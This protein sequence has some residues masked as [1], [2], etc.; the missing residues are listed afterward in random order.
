LVAEYFTNGTPGFTN[1]AI[2]IGETVQ[3]SLSLKNIGNA[4]TTNNVSATLLTNSSVLPAQPNTSSD[5]DLLAPG[6]SAKV[7]L[8]TFTAAGTNGGT[9]TAVLSLKDGAN[10]L[11]TASFSF[12]LPSVS[13]F[14]NTNRIDIPT[15]QQDQQQPGPASPYPSSILVSGAT[16]LVGKVTVTLSNLNH[17]FPHD[18]NLLLVSPTGGKALLMSDAADGSSANGVNLTFD[19]S[20]ASTLPGFG[21]ITS[22]S[23]QPSVYDSAAVL[24]SPAPAGPYGAALAFFNGTDPNGTW[25]LYAFDDTSGDFGNVANGW[26]LAISTANP[27]SKPTD[28]SVSV[29]SAPASTRVGD[30]VTNIFTVTNAGPSKSGG[31]WF[32]NLLPAGT[33][34]VSATN[35]ALNPFFTNGNALSCYLGDALD[36]NA[37]AT[38]TL[39]L[40][41][42]GTNSPISL[43]GTVVATNGAIDLNQ[44]NNTAST[45]TTVLLPFADIAVTQSI[46]PNPAVLGFPLTN[47]VRVTN[48][49][50]GIAFGVLLTNTLP[51]GAGLFSTVPSG[52]Y[53]G[54]KVTLQLGDIAANTAVTAIIVVTNTDQT[55]KTNISSVATV[56]IDSN[57][58]NNSATNSVTV[59]SP[60]LQIAS[61]SAVLLSESGPKNGF[62][63]IGETN[64]VDLYLQ[65]VGNIPT[66]NLV[67][68][69]LATNGVLLNSGAQIQTYGSLGAG[70]LV[71]RPFTFTAGSGNGG[72]VL[73]TLRLQDGSVVTNVTFAILSRA[74]FSNTFAITIPDHGTAVSYPS[75]ITISGMNGVVANARA[76]L[77]GVNHTFPRDINALLANPGNSDV[78]LM[79]H[80]GGAHSLPSVTLTFDD[81]AAN[82]LSASDQITSG[83]FKPTA[84]GGAVILPSPAPDSPY[85]T[86]LAGVAGGDPN[87]DWSLYIFDDTTGDAGNVASGWT[88]DL[89]T[90]PVIAPPVLSASFSGGQVH[91]AINSQPGT[92]VIY[93]SWDLSNWIPLSTNTA[94][95]S[96][97]ITYTDPNSQNYQLRY[98]RAVRLLP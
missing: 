19:D 34:L 52:T 83:A 17:T 81:A 33:L 37:S 96:G 30:T 45:V 97:S 41:P 9:I 95:T 67:A 60:F 26:S 16:G 51:A 43:S 12:V 13:K 71:H 94:S 23:W 62:I 55:P 38:I 53:L 54:G 58:V 24:S 98:Y 39:V 79:S 14:A 93:G 42:I 82:S 59:A 69:L 40:S 18:I 74:V 78:L 31:L 47:T 92:Y 80:A 50:P 27:L 32:T 89:T 68:T 5:Y 36:V 7:H 4:S 91:L 56:S 22:G 72:N 77:T 48:A 61:A 25:S 87:G 11:G 20:A 88:L 1:G 63:D 75:T 70:A 3:L 2:D 65:N 86:A 49:G 8:F 64:T 76:T 10:D 85:G 84:Y 6:G 90:T 29:V 73:A 35:S 66:T 21:Q 28:L 46:S 57:S 44:A 15:T